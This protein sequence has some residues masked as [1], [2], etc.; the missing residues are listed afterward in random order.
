MFFFNLPRSSAPAPASAVAVPAL[1][2][3]A[4]RVSAT[5]SSPVTKTHSTAETSTVPTASR[6]AALALKVISCSVLRISFVGNLRE[7]KI[8]D[9]FELVPGKHYKP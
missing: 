9:R 4:T 5:G 8:Q 3:A 2:G 6:E 1:T 7:G